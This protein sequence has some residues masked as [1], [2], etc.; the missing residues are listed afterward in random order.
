MKCGFS[1]ITQQRSY[2][3]YLYFFIIDHE[4]STPRTC[5]SGLA[6]KFLSKSVVGWGRKPP[7]WGN[8][9]KFRCYCCRYHLLYCSHC[10]GYRSAFCSPPADFVAAFPYNYVAAAVL[11]SPA[12]SIT[13]APRRCRAHRSDRPRRRTNALL[14][15]RSS[16]SSFLVV[17]GGSP[18][19]GRCAAEADEAISAAVSGETEHPG[20]PVRHADANISCNG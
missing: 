20:R 17:G 11:F 12:P 2:K 18:S 16:L 4:I 3:R 15:S 5:V 9:I 19:A 8:L 1:R 6:F 13:I 10:P 14:S 7:E